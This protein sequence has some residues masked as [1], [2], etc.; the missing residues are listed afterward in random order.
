[1]EEKKQIKWIELEGGG[2]H[3]CTIVN[4]YLV[5]VDVPGSEF[6]YCIGRIPKEIQSSL[7]KCLERLD[8][9]PGDCLDEFALE[10]EVHTLEWAISRNIIS[11][12]EVEYIRKRI[13][14]GDEV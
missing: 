3:F 8:R 2:R 14:G 6:N 1:M 7:E 9:T 5:S 13:L 11:R 12:E 4:N 10:V